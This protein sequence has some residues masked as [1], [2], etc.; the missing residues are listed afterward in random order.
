MSE[1]L[2]FRPLELPRSELSL[3]NRLVMAPM[4]TFAAEPTGEASATELAWYARRA[5]SGLAAVVTAGCAVAAEGVCFAGQ[6]RCDGERFLDSLARVRT[7]IEEAGALAVL[8]LVWCG[9]FTAAPAPERI[10]R[11]F[12]AAARRAQRAGYRAVE[13]HGGHRDLLQQFFSRRTN[14]RVSGWGGPDVAGRARL[15]LVA[16]EAAAENVLSC[17]Y[18][19]DPEE[20][21][22]EG[23]TIEETLELTELLVERGV[24][25]VDVAAKSH[26]AGSIRE[27]D[28]RP[29]A[30]LVA[31]RLQ[32][33][34]ATTLA[35]GG[36]R[37]PAQAARALAEGA[38]LIGL[39]RVLIRE[40]DWAAKVREGR[41][42]ELRMSPADDAS[43]EGLDVPPP[44]VAFLKRRAAGSSS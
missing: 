17:W 40:P 27:A 8:Q 30:Q 25:V 23:V 13:I 42:A 24:E 3:P 2:L 26:A 28:S 32:G 41:T 20:P 1:A 29:R 35:A 18:R 43:L 39:G 21:E 10:V 36:F 5:S 33:K 38:D 7:A 19:L 12:A 15:P 22:P 11:A 9:R 37:K 4:P 6:W 44:I 14:S 31:E 34:A 16:A